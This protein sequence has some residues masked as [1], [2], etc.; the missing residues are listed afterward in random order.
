MGS[1]TTKPLRRIAFLNP[2]SDP[3]G[4]IGEPDCGGQCIVEEKLMHWITRIDP[5]IRVESYTRRHSGKPREEKIG[6]RATVHRIPC[7]G[8]GFIRKEDLYGHLPEFKENTLKLWQEKGYHYDILHGHYADGGAVALMLSEQLGI[9]YLFTAHSLGKVKQQSLPDGPTGSTF[10]YHERIPWEQRVIDDAHRIIALNEIERN[11]YYQGLYK[12]APEK[13]RV[14]PNAVDLG[15]FPFPPAGEKSRPPN[16]RIVFTTGRLDDRKGFPL[17]AGTLEKAAS[18]LEE[19]GL[20][21]RYRFPGGGSRLTG[22]EHCVLDAI[23]N[24]VPAAFRDRLEFFPRLGF[25]ELVRAYQQADVFVCA[26]PYEPF[27]LVILEAMAVGTPAVAGAGSGGPPEIIA[28][29]VDGVLADLHDTADFADKLV[30]LLGDDETRR[31]MGENARRKVE[32]RYSWASVAETTLN[33][34][35]EVNAK[36]GLCPI[37]RQKRAKKRSLHGSK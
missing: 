2:H 24:A 27:G 35:R 10:H 9:P 23:K 5:E 33:L 7:A 36:A 16:E 13:V 32:E 37:T 34:Y 20:R 30:R 22:E 14:I 12:A 29:G 8:E 18:D 1:T 19:Q 26:S 6:E 31:R 15:Q 21:A 4:T 25:P 17:L 28:D 11:D 3:L